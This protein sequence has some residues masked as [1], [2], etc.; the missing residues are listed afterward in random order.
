MQIA[1]PKENRPG[2]LRVAASPETVQKFITM[3]FDVI[4]EKDAGAG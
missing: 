3:G 1:I 4:V 2:E